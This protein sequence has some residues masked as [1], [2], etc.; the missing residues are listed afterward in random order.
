MSAIIAGMTTGVTAF[1]AG[2]CAA[3][4]VPLP[5]G[6]VHDSRRR[7]HVLGERVL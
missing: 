4:R 5:G 6:L 1:I 2:D 3:A 7:R